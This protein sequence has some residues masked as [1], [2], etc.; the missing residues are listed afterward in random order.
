MADRKFIPFW[1]I[2]WPFPTTKISSTE[3]SVKVA[4]IVAS[5]NKYWS[6]AVG[7][8]DKGVAF[9]TGNQTEFEGLGSLFG[10]EEND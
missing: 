3:H 5:N 4:G 7:D 1:P 10:A 6:I 9:P 2:N 8:N